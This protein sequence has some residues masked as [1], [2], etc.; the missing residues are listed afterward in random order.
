MKPVII[1]VDDES[2]ILESLK[3]A[4]KENFGKSYSIETVESGDEGI[5]L[6][7]NLIKK[8]AE[9][10]IIISDYIM[11]GLKGDEVLIESHQ[12]IPNAQK[13]MLTGQADMTGVKN[14]INNAKLYRFLTKPWNKDDLILTISEALKSFEQTKQLEIQ[15]KELEKSEKKYKDLVENSLDIIFSLDSENKIVSV[16]KSISRILK[17]NM[18]TIIGKKFIDLIYKSAQEISHLNNDPKSIPKPSHNILS[19]NENIFKEKYQELLVNKNIVS[20]NCEL[21][22]EFGEPK[23][24]F[25]KLQYIPSGD[26]FVI[27]GKASDIEEDTLIK[28]CESESQIYKLGNFLTHVDIVCQRLSSAIL[29]YSN[30]ETSHNLRLCLK[31]LL[32]NSIEHGNLDINFDEKTLAIKNGDYLQFLLNK[33]K[34]PLNKNKKVIL[35]YSLTP[36]KISIRIT[37]EGKGFDHKKMMAKTGDDENGLELGHGRGIIIIRSFFDKMEYN[38]KGNS[39]FL[40]KYFESYSTQG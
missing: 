14:A 26:N 4:I 2:I 11:P 35:E 18:N 17:Y 28:L 27:F 23:E 33:Q 6:I 29:K 1:C 5:E 25:I 16:N 22:T 32:I 7:E 34:N 12:I 20:F 38:E 19:L 9:I 15:N 40:E 31:E 30:P 10:P 36:Q 39:V 8:G 21:S 24:M 37:D 3:I 13:I